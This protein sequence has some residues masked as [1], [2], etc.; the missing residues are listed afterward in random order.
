MDGVAGDE[1]RVKNYTPRNSSAWIMERAHRTQTYAVKCADTAGTPTEDD[2]IG[3]SRT[4]FDGQTFE[5]AP[6][7]GLATQRQEGRKTL[8]D[9]EGYPGLRGV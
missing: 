1:Q 2:V 4:L 9:E 5:T 3:E 8:S 7:K 6:V